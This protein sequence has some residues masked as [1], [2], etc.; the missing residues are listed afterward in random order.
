MEE[1][2]GSEGGG[3]DRGVREVGKIERWR[4]GGGRE[5]ESGG[6]STKLSE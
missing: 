2:G 4:E 5:E 3:K 1:G 6:E